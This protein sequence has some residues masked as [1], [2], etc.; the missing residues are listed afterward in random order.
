MTYKCPKCGRYGMEWD[1][2]TK[3]ILCYY[4][5]CNYVIRI[6]NQKERPSEEILLAAIQGDESVTSK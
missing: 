3:V 5:S 4:V 2:R 6:R 1:A